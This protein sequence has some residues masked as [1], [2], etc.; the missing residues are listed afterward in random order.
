MN[1]ILNRTAVKKHILHRCKLVR[2]GWD[3]RRVSKQALVEIEAFII[4]KINE[5]IRRHPTKGKT[6]MHFD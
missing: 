1:T 2:P 3:C 6:F 4:F 5:S